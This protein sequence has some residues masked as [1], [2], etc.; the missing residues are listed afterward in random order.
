[1]EARKH[2]GKKLFDGLH[3]A[4]QVAGA[5]TKTRT[6][7]IIEVLMVKKPEQGYAVTREK[8]ISFLL[9]ACFAC[10]RTFCHHNTG[11]AAFLPTEQFCFFLLMLW[12]E[13]RK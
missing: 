5:S 8:N 1:M 9:N 12:I 6:L 7:F 11:R 10:M 3:V 13:G 2:L 4:G